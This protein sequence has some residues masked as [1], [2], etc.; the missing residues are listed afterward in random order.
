MRKIQQGR[1]RP[2]QNK[3]KVEVSNLQVEFLS[4]R[5]TIKMLR[6]VI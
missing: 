5:E 6:F 1:G 3:H 2:Y 4:K